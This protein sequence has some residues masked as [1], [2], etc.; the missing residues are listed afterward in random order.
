[1][2]APKGN[3]LGLIQEQAFIS[4]CYII[5]LISANNFVIISHVLQWPG[6]SLVV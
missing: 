1:L 3:G 6:S 5:W 4:P 2:E